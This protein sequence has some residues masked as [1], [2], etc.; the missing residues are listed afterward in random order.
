MRQFLKPLLQ[1]QRN[2]VFID[3]YRIFTDIPFEGFVAAQINLG[4]LYSQGIGVKK[5]LDKALEW[6]RKAA[7]QGNEFAKEK[8]TE[9]E[10]R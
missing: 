3:A 5:D 8:V 9:I 6:Y 1:K 2:P 7:E 10:N 4:Q